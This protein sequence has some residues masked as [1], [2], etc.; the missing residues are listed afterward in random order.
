MY[1]IKKEKQ[2]KPNQPTKK[3]KP[4]KNPA[5]SPPKIQKPKRKKG[6]ST[7]N[8]TQQLVRGRRVKF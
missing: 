4:Q 6:K 1:V 5:K 2:I 8:K 3:P 7:Q